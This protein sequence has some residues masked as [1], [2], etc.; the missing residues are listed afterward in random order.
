MTDVS[1]P[2]TQTL[3]TIPEKKPFPEDR[4]L[5][6]AMAREKA[7]EVRRRNSV[8]RKQAEISHMESLLNANAENTPENYEAK[9]DSTV[10]QTAEP[11]IEDESINE[12]PQIPKVAPVKKKKATK[13]QMVVVEQSSDDSDE[14]EPN[15]NVV[16]VKRVRKKKEAIRETQQTPTPPP[17][18]EPSHKPDPQPRM[19][20]ADAIQR[21][22]AAHQIYTNMFNG[23]FLNRRW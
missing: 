12:P 3:S 14:F 7:L 21:S 18:A 2:Q 4:A 5:K 20:Q 11:P 17:P 23:Q 8:L 10:S 16:F 15:Q 9:E 22:D 19:Q 6:L 13:R 1:K